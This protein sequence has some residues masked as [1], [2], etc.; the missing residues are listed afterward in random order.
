MK[1]L[2]DDEAFRYNYE[3]AGVGATKDPI[4]VE[5]EEGY[6]I[7]YPLIPFARTFDTPHIEYRIP[8]FHFCGTL[9]Q[10][11]KMISMQNRKEGK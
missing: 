10:V 5:L 3:Q 1:Q 2:I 8:G 11:T 7:I 4:R 6:A 9:K